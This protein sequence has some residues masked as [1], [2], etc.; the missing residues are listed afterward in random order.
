MSASCTG[1][2]QIADKIPTLSS[3]AADSRTN[4]THVFI[5]DNCAW[6]TDDQPALIESLGIVR[7]I[8]VAGE[9]FGGRGAVA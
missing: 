8:K 7:R 9:H 6:L 4:E 3:V 2:A 1:L 5:L